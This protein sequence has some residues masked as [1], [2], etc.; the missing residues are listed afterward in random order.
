MV[1][2][3][4]ELQNIIAFCYIYISNNMIIALCRHQSNNKKWANRI[5]RSSMTRLLRYCFSQVYLAI[6]LYHVYMIIIAWSILMAWTNKYRD[7]THEIDPR[8]KLAII[9]QCLHFTQ[10]HFFS[11]LLVFSLRLL[12]VYSISWSDLFHFGSILLDCV[13]FCS[14]VDFPLNFSVHAIQVFGQC[15]WLLLALSADLSFCIERYAKKTI[16]MKLICVC[17][18][19]VFYS[20]F[21]L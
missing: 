11:L 5:Y 2:H 3:S 7:N 17:S 10:F 12:F 9:D 20:E 8:N 19:K 13:I 15:F 14:F 4:T 1:Q 16:R 18:I 21:N 6:K